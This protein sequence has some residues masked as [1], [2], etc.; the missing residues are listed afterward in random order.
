MLKKINKLFLTATAAAGLIL[1]SA[2]NVFA[3]TTAECTLNGQPV[4]C[5]EL[6]KQLGGMLGNLGI[7]AVVFAIIGLA[8][9][10]FWLMMLIHAATHPINNKALWIVVLVFTGI[11][12]AILYYFLVKRS[13]NKIMP[14][15][16]ASM[17]QQSD[18][19]TKPPVQPM[20]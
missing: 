14:T 16:S 12:G 19:P 7:F 17:S 10:I 8:C 20:M 9:A 15:A 2:Q 5:D 11:I 18:Q 3:Q 4:S 6:N 13:F 1:V